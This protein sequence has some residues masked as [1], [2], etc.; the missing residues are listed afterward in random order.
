MIIF[1]SRYV[2]KQEVWQV[3]HRLHAGDL[4]ALISMTL[5]AC[6]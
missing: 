5:K 3:S 4:D 6:M 2:V 1:V